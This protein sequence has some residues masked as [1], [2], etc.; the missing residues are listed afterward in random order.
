MDIKKDAKKAVKKLEKE[1][2]EITDDLKDAVDLIRSSEKTGSKEGTRADL[3]QKICRL[4]P[5]KVDNDTV[6]NV[7][8][9]MRKAQKTVKKNFDNL[10]DNKK[11][12]KGHEAAIKKYK[13]YIEDQNKYADM[14]YGDSTMQYSG[15]EIFAAYN[16][17]YNITGRHE[18]LSEMIAA[19]E[20]DGMILSGKFGTAPKAIADQLKKMGFKTQMTTVEKEFDEI[21]K[22][23]KSLILT[24]YNDKN[25]LSQEVHTVNISKDGE[26]YTAHNVYCNGKTVGPYKS[27]SELIKNI[28]SGKAK[29]ISLIGITK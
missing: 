17:I 21:G 6:V 8:D 18:E 5:N 26:S 4:I 28:N 16:A 9:L 15:C 11:A 1:V 25:D 22:K 14:K 23:A 24:M 19:F 7:L 20:K 13:G 3:F 2:N 12:F 27:V 10:P 29:G